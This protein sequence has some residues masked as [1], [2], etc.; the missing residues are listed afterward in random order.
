MKYVYNRI[1]K[2]LS[3]RS[4]GEKGDTQIRQN[5]Y[6]DRDLAHS[7][8]DTHTHAHTHTSLEWRHQKNMFWG[9]DEN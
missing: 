9:R 4:K 2:I 3:S 5:I 6:T 8:T 7:G 1:R